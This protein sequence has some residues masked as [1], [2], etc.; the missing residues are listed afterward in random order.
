[1]TAVT[2]SRSTLRVKRDP[3]RDLAPYDPPV[4][5]LHPRCP[6]LQPL[7][8]KVRVLEEVPLQGLAKISRQTETGKGAPNLARRTQPALLLLT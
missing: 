6:P 1:M 7:R 3:C 8:L 4:R 2:I 5:T